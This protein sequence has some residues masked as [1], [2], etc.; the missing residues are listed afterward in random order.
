MVIAGIVSY[1]PNIARLRENIESV[2][3]Q[4]DRVVLVDNGSRNFFDIQL[5]IESEDKVLLIKNEQNRGIA[6]ALNQLLDYAICNCATWLLTLDQDSVVSHEYVKK[7]LAGIISSNTALLAPNILD[8]SDIGHHLVSGAGVTEVKECITSGTMMN[9]HIC[10]QIGC[11]DEKMFI[12]YVD[13]D[14][15]YRVRKSGYDIFKNND[16]ILLHQLGDGCVRS[17]LGKIFIVANHSADRH[18]YLV[19]NCVYLIKK[20]GWLVRGLRRIFQE[21]FIVVIYEKNCILKLKYMFRGLF[22]G[23]R[24]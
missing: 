14:Y 17:F 5:L 12:D 7:M 11:F 15:C 13:F 16:V 1:N 21:Y 9:V 4:V 6:A 2:I 22:D 24:L 20:H 10:K 8:R 19:R 3:N 23:M 18:Y